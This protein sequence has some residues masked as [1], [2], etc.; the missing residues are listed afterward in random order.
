[1]TWQRTF[2]RIWFD[3]PERPEFAAWRDK[4]AELHPDWTIRT[5]DSSDEVRSL[6]DDQ[7]SLREMWDRYMDSD[8][9]GRIPDIARYL[10]LWHHGGVYTDTDMEWLRPVDPL[11]ADPRPFAAWENDRT[12][13]TAVLAAPKGHD[14]IGDLLRGLVQRLHDTEGMTANNA[15]GPEYA[16]ALWR[17]RS[18]VRRLPPSYF[19]PIG[20]WEKGILGHTQLPPETYAVHWW[21]KGWDPAQPKSAPRPRSSSQTGVSILV[22]FRDADGTRTRLWSFVHE[23]LQRLY[24]EA[25]IIVASDDGEDP[26]HKT[27]ALNRA[28]AQATGDIFVIYD[29]DTLVDVD[30]L[31]ET[32]QQVRENPMRWAQPFATKV[33][34]NQAA[35]EHI[36]AQGSTWGGGLN[37]REFGQMESRT[38]FQQAPP[39]VVSREAWDIVGGMDER[40][41]EGWGQEDL[42]FA[43]ALRVLVGQPLPRRRNEAWHLW[44]E[45]IGVSGNDLWPGQTAEGKK[46]HIW[47]AGQYRAAR[48]PEAMRKLL[49]G[50]HDGRRLHDRNGD[51]APSDRRGAVRVG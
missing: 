28:G 38:A 35:T 46:Y 29:A 22:P 6:I 14:A 11:L 50:A 17:E 45:R 15:A 32:V 4:L 39:L 13:C 40:F 3:E 34:L 44:H 24:P 9:F 51:G 12:M 20:W 37:I 18:D 25:E 41:S 49:E 33:K 47:L 1:M 36:L 10:I 16:T 27:L 43:T 5:W 48:K 42:A 7:P 2:H 30:A 8:P 26:F 19:F 21:N 23:R 31:R